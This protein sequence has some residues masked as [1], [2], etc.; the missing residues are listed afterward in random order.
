MLVLKQLK[1]FEST[2]VLELLDI[3]K[4]VRPSVI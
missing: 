1:E 4:Q 3:P 2:G